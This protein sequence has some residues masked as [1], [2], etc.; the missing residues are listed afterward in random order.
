[1]SIEC[2][3]CT[4]NGAD[5][6]SQQLES[7]EY[8]TCSFDKLIV[9]DDASKD[10]TVEIISSWSKS[11]DIHVEIIVN[12][13]CLGVVG[14]FEKALSYTK[15]DYIFF[16][17]Q[18]DVWMPS[19]VELSMECMK[20]LES[21]YGQQMPC[22][23]HTDLSV[24]DRELNIIHKSFMNNQGLNHIYDREKQI[25][26]LM[27]QNFVTGCTMVINRALK[28]K[29]TPF[30]TGIIMH[31]YWIALVA[32]MSGRLGVVDVPTILY[33]Q[34]GRNTV[35]AVRY[36]SV[37]NL[38]KISNVEDMLASIGSMLKQIRAVTEYKDGALVIDKQCVRNFL[39]DVDKHRYYKV[40]LSS[41]RKQGILCNIFFKIY[42]MV[43][44][45]KN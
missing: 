27:A 5:H 23:V 3:L 43:Y 34:H 13:S 40:L 20:N 32:A 25:C 44:M 18:D 36:L 39:E 16:A 26:S 29:A 41:V 4:Y 10:N 7:I 37:K 21:K 30:P 22:L 9:C 31:D 33:R 35:G 28:E 17:D 1:M 42:M 8:Q 6:I 24:V 19:K 15:G 38:L 11:T 45:L 2:V 14:N 12:D